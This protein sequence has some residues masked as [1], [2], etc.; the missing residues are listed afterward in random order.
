MTR[1]MRPAM[2]PIKSIDYV[3]NVRQSAPNLDQERRIEESII[4]NGLF[5]PIKV[6]KLPKNR[7]GLVGGFTRVKI[8]K[9]M[10]SH[11]VPV[12]FAGT[13]EIV[14][15]GK[16][17]AIECGS[18]NEEDLWFEAV[19][20][21][22]EQRQISSFDMGAHLYEIVKRFYPQYYE[23][24]WS[25]EKRV[26]VKAFAE[27][28]K[29]DESHVYQWLRAFDDAS[30]KLK[31]SFKEKRIAGEQY[32]IISR[33]GTRHMQELAL[34]RVE[35]THANPKKTRELV[36]LY[37][38]IE[39]KVPAAKPE[40]REKAIQRYETETERRQDEHIAFVDLIDLPFMRSVHVNVKS[41]TCPPDR[42]KLS[43]IPC[44]Y[45]TLT[46][47]EKK[48]C[49]G[50]LKKNGQWVKTGSPCVK[51]GYEFDLADWKSSITLWVPTA[52][53]GEVLDGLVKELQ[54]RINKP[55]EPLPPS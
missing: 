16:I 2:I 29:T 32:R 38:R 18:P 14:P 39:E 44:P 37:K 45:A 47:D 10:H 13:G 12:R 48:K 15:V 31:Q 20:D 4:E 43:S 21:N 46:D 41:L 26:L 34:N 51:R 1:P 30:P 8:F 22:W 52:L 17:P 11:H 7:Y 35:K 3:F 42:I 28:L 54:K 49:D 40:E 53:C 33:L 6:R 25:K 19:T 5:K 50:Y 23:M 9:H 36:S 27:K 24:K 55:P